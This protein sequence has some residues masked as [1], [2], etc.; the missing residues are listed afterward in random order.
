MTQNQQTI[1]L[2]W[3]LLERLSAIQDRRP[4]VSE[5]MRSLQYLAIQ[6]GAE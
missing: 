6:L 1:A 5:I 2:I 4:Q 3:L